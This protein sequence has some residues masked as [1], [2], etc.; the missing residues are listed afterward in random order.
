MKLNKF[1]FGMSF[2]VTTLAVVAAESAPVID[3]TKTGAIKSS[4]SQYTSSVPETMAEK[5]VN[6]ER[7]LDARNRA[8]VKVQRQL[9][10]LQNEVNELRGVTELHT[11]QLSQVLNRQR[12]LYQELDRRVTEALKPENNVPAAI[13]APAKASSDASINYST[14]LTENQAYDSAVNLV[15][16]DKQYDKAIPEFQAFNRNFPN[17]S[18][19]PNAHYW[20]GQLLFNK[21]EY[22]KA[23]NE[24]NLVVEQY[25]DSNKRSDAMLKLAMVEQKLNNNAAAKIW[26][27]KVLAQ[28]P[29]S[30]AA[31]LAKP[32]LENL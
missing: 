6:L 14:N 7:K 26:Y 25:L 11:H 8:Q 13:I 32:R 10:E 9:D 17:S 4:P 24:F 22:T 5:L 30:S 23:K 1:L 2:A 18:Y 28:Y 31:Q 20:L 27:Q 16:K 19:A 3:I 12:E 21:T 29:D 15:L